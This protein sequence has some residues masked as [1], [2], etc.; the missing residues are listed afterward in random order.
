MCLTEL[1]AP[2]ESR[3]IKFYNVNKMTLITHL[4]KCNYKTCTAVLVKIKL[5]YKT[6]ALE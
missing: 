1:L 2:S 5:K 4:A 6:Y 3:L